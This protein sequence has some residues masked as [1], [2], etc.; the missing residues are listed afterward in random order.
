[1]LSS[2][3]GLMK[4]F[5][6][7]KYGVFCLTALLVTG[8]F[9]VSFGVVTAATL[10]APTASLTV[11]GSHSATFIAGD[12]VAYAWAST[13]ADKFT[14]SYASKCGN[15]AWIANSS[16]GTLNSVIAVAQTGCTYTITYTVTQS[17]TGVKVS[18]V[19]TLNVVAPALKTITISPLS[20]SLKCTLLM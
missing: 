17:A 11:N 1:M 14:S 13:N 19:I 15:G 9:F 7:R 5:D 6:F 16:K 4:S 8:G 3:Y 20:T 12:T 10:P 18:D 2:I